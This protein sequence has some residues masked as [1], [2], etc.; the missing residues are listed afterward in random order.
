MRHQEWTAKMID[1]IETL[2]GGGA[3]RETRLSLMPEGLGKVDVSIRQ[4]D[5]GSLHVA[6]NT[7]TQAARQLIADAQP[8]LAE[9]AQERGIRIGS[10][11]VESNP[12]GSNG[13]NGTGAN[14][15]AGA[16][17]QMNQGQRHDA[18]PQ[19]NQ[20]SAPPGARRE[21]APSTH[22]DERVA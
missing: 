18:Q 19:R 3:A 13:G 12:T 7:D 21:A 9:I 11:S 14:G 22:D 5:A 4:D 10:T 1:K 6:F 17:A 20:P 16:N 2:Q 15:N 8:K